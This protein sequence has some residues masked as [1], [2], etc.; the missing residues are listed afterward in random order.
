MKDELVDKI[1]PSNISATGV[2]TLEKEPMTMETAP[3]KFQQQMPQKHDS[4][5]GEVLYRIT[6]V[7]TEDC[8]VVQKSL[9]VSFYPNFIVIE[10]ETKVGMLCSPLR[11]T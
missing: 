4:D 3:N 1:E 5:F 6:D 2:T 7:K 9:H 11:V 10:D 8:G